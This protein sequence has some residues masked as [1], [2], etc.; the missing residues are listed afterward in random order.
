MS[1]LQLLTVTQVA[2]SLSISPSLVYREAANGRLRCYRLGRG[3][4][5]FS[6][7]QI[8]E[9]LNS[10]VCAPSSAAQRPLSVPKLRHLKV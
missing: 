6:P 4:I 1:N 9:Y 10:C 8:Q 5:R 2:E 7:E 3:A